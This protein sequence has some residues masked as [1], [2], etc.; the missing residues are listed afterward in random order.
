MYKKCNLPSCIQIISVKFTVT[1]FTDI[2]YTEL[3]KIY[4]Y[5]VIMHDTNKN[6]FKEMRQR[7]LLKICPKALNNK[8][9]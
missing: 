3:K 5:V 7:T 9:E 1:I 4:K 2:R 8:K 6:I